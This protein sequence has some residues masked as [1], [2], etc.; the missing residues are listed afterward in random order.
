MMAAAVL[1]VL[2]WEQ[3]TPA[4]HAAAVA[5]ACLGLAAWLLARALFG[6]RRQR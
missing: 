2:G 5:G 4:E 6:G 3:L 1:D